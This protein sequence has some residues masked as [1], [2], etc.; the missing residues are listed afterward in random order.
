MKY[1][2]YILQCT[3]PLRIPIPGHFLCNSWL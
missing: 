2:V 1:F 3:L